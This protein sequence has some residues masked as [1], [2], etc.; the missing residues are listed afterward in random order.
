MHITKTARDMGTF[1][2]DNDIVTF[3]L[4]PKS[5]KS[6]LPFPKKTLGRSFLKIKKKRVQ[7]VS[8]SD[9]LRLYVRLFLKHSKNKIK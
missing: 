9:K 3:Y 1:I 2:F 5:E 4:V 6:K 8:V 7:R